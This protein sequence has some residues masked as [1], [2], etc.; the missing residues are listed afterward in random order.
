VSFLDELGKVKIL[1]WHVW[2]LISYSSRSS[3]LQSE[4]IS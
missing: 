3:R 4:A 2:H 1:V